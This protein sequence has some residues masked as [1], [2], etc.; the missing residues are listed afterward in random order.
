MIYTGIVLKLV[1]T[2]DSLKNNYREK[3]KEKMF[4]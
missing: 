3:I 1:F 4:E 2:K